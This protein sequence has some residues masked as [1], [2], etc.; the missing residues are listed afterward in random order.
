[1]AADASTTPLWESS[2]ENAA[3][4]ERGRS[5]TVLEDALLTR[6]V[7]QRRE[8][9]QF[10]EDLVE[11]SSKDP[12]ATWMAYIKYHQDSFPNETHEQ[13]LLLERC[14]RG[15][16]R[17]KHY[18]NDIRYI[19]IC[20]A[21]AVQTSR[22]QEIFHSLCNQHVG[23][24]VS[25][26]WVA[27]AWIAEKQKDYAA[28]DALLQK[29]LVEGAKPESYL[30]ER[31]KQFERRFAKFVQQQESLLVEE[32]G[33]DESRS[34][35]PLGGLS[36][37]AVIRNDRQRTQP[38]GSTTRT[39]TFVDRSQQQRQQPQPT[40]NRMA[41]AADFQIYNASDEENAWQ[42]QRFS[43]TAQSSTDRILETER[44][45]RKE[46]TQ[47]AEPWNHRGGLFPE[48]PAAGTAVPTSAYSGA[49][50]TSP[51]TTFAVHVDQE[52]IHQ[53]EQD[54]LQQ[55]RYHTTKRHHR[56]ER[57]FRERCP[58][59][60]RDS[61]RYLR[62]PSLVDVD[63]QLQ[64][65]DT[66]VASRVTTSSF[67]SA[68]STVTATNRAKQ[69]PS[70]SGSC[71]Y[72]SSLLKSLLGG[73]QSFEQARAKA[74]HYTIAGPMQNVNNLFNTE[75]AINESWD[76]DVSM[77]DITTSMEEVST[78]GSME[79][80][81]M[82]RRP[83]LIP[84][85]QLVQ[86][87]ITSISRNGS[88]LS[89]FDSAASS[90]VHNLSTDSSIV[91]EAIAVGLPKA[92]ETINTAMAR[93]ELSMMF[94]GSP[95]LAPVKENF[96]IF[97]DNA[98]E[99]FCAADSSKS[100]Y[101]YK[102][103][104][105]E[106]PKR[107][108]Q[109][110]EDAIE[111]T[112]VQKNPAV[113]PAPRF[114]IYTELDTAAAPPAFEFF[115]DSQQSV[116]DEN[117]A[118]EISDPS[119]INVAEK[120]NEAEPTE[121]KPEQINPAV[122]PAARFQIYTE[123]D[124]AAAPTFEIFNDSQQ[125]VEDEKA[126]FEISDPSRINVV[127]K[128]NEA[129]PNVDVAA[130]EDDDTTATLFARFQDELGKD[131]RP[132]FSSPSGFSMSST[133]P[134]CLQQGVDP[135][136]SGRL[137]LHGPSRYSMGDT[138]PLAMLQDALGEDFTTSNHTSRLPT[139]SIHSRRKS[140]L[141]LSAVQEDGKE[142]ASLSDMYTIDS[143][144]HIVL[145]GNSRYSMGDTAPLAMLQEALGEDNT[146]T[147][148]PSLQPP[149]G[150]RSRRTSSLF[151]QPR[152]SLSAVQEDDIETAPLPELDDADTHGPSWYSIGDTAPLAMLLQALGEDSS[153]SS[154][155]TR[156]ST[157]SIRGRRKSSN[158][159]PSRLSLSAVQEDGQDTAPLS[160]I[161]D[162]FG[163][164]ESGAT[165]S[166]HGALGVRIAEDVTLPS[167]GDISLIAQVDEPTITMSIDL[168]VKRAVDYATVRKRDLQSA[169]NRLKS[170]AQGYLPP[171]ASL[172]EVFSRSDFVCSCPTDVLPRFF[173]EKE[174]SNGRFIRIGRGKSE[175]I[176]ELGR[177]AFG[178]VTLVEV[179][180]TGGV[181]AVKIQKPAGCLAS[182]YEIMRKLSV[183]LDEKFP[184]AC[185]ESFPRALSYM[186]LADG[187]IMSMSAASASGL[188]LIDLCNVY[189]VRLECETP[190]IIILHY[191]ARMLYHLELL[192]WHGQLLHCDAKPDNWVLSKSSLLNGS[193]IEASELMLV[194]F[195]R[196]IDLESGKLSG[197]SAMDTKFLGEASP[198]NMM[199]VAMRQGL[200][201]SFDID[202]FGVCAAVHALLFGEHIVIA[203]TTK[204]RWMPIRS[205][206]RNNQT[207]LWRDLFDSL[208]NL[209]DVSNTCLGS[210]PRSVRQL[211]TR[212]EGFLAER[213]DKLEA[214]LRSQASML[215][216]RR[217]DL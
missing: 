146:I 5:V 160:V 204:G 8:R 215:P 21:Y 115:N 148:H 214:A 174:A 48:E 108:F 165:Y 181:I 94:Y 117:A 167:F 88:L 196:A 136:N 191:A 113:V 23:A 177:G 135:D 43:G 13:F 199:C 71:A 157:P 17:T 69:K 124:K 183:R 213:Q 132:T 84:G 104:T 107:A 166:V 138:A 150:I 128:Q 73:E 112:P 22:P 85:K 131:N 156:L 37:E 184:K 176:N 201:W 187:A 180:Q 14:V 121:E 217:Q 7:E 186:S 20:C 2:K 86:T 189:K 54:E 81:S 129:E 68:A 109:V 216:A 123:S 79:D 44:Q 32:D 80:V 172:S 134:I 4:L 151:Q 110:F 149:A 143:R 98:G 101:I 55:K 58:V 203:K 75:A 99:S 19:R 205:I 212:I 59:V 152:L 60:E 103:A 15:L 62:D 161:G 78:T 72:K 154:S 119:K 106:L 155:P 89:S 206:P 93:K 120:Q 137:A 208:L 194:D 67:T 9:I 141:L 39:A 77:E 130:D 192:H 41:T 185:G 66:K 1:M 33:Y 118:F 198:E 114:Q 35:G 96:S 25:I 162:L 47:A 30:R 11:A 76:S 28:A 105:N 175:V 158:F 18:Q 182:E 45:V 36:Q 10:F 145:P 64:M 61:L 95:S 126:T 173:K 197:L 207:I 210:H 190:G 144:S 125:S 3:P 100:F 49:A 42:Q 170:V 90:R 202:T 133:S 70:V 159:Q 102:D 82:Q 53:Q 83:P 169:A 56:D 188:N 24:R 153:P 164:L 38:T 122:V 63:Q 31:Y 46:N 6:T 111:E 40:S 26:F 74:G 211:R 57:T 140:R 27:W 29:G 12:L 51:S 91:D 34:R 50:F 178:V 52:C 209:D 139:P 87:S 116:E 200:P 16:S 195:G 147:S 171:N 65:K 92:E 193:V 142:S 168:A 127:E 179:E 163:K 97:D